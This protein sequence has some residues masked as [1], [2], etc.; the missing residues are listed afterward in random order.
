MGEDFLSERLTNIWG[1]NE[2]DPFSRYQLDWRWSGNFPV[3]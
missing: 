2:L 1:R 3:C